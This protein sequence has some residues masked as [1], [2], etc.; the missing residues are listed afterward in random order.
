MTEHL[1]WLEFF[2]GCMATF[3]LALLISQEEGPGDV[4][5]KLRESTPGLGHRALLRADRP[6]ALARFAALLVGVFGRSHCAEP[7][8]YQGKNVAVT[9]AHIVFTFLW[10]ERCE[11]K[12]FQV[13]M[14]GESVSTGERYEEIKTLC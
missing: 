11:G 3:R 2:V 10:Q 4:A 8:V 7:G 13:E 12:D 9:G 6:A 14:I 5:R 1:S